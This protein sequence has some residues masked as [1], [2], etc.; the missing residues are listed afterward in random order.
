M[1]IRILKCFATSRHCHSSISGSSHLFLYYQLLLM[2]VL[3]I[4]YG[5][6]RCGVTDATVLCNAEQVPETNFLKK[7]KSQLF[8]PADVPV[9]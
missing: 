2:C 4:T 9:K 3:H 5:A 8:L 6:L 1:H 7:D